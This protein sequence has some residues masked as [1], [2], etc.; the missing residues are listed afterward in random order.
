[1]K[2][3]PSKSVEVEKEVEQAEKEKEAEK[4]KRIKEEMEARQRFGLPGGRHIRY[5]TEKGDYELWVVIAG[6]PSTEL[7]LHLNMAM[8]L[9]YSVFQLNKTMT[10]SYDIVLQRVGG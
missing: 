3:S 1:M 5:H 2:K 10:G 6:L 8:Y 4:Q 9:G 7:Q